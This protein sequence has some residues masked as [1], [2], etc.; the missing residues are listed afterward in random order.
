MMSETTQQLKELG[1]ECHV[2]KSKTVSQQNEIDSLKTANKKLADNL[3]ILNDELRSQVTDKT[4]QEEK[5]KSKIPNTD[6]SRAHFFL[7]CL[8]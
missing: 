4:E 2:H 7:Y 3:R 8:Q 5:Y 1:D 6:V